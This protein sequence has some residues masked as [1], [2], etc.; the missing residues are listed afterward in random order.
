MKSRPQP[1]HVSGQAGAKRQNALLYTFLACSGISGQVRDRWFH[2]IVREARAGEGVSPNNSRL[3]LRLFAAA[4]RKVRFHHR[5]ARVD[6]LV[7][8]NKTEQGKAAVPPLSLPDNTLPETVDQVITHAIAAL[9]IK[10]REVLLLLDVLGLTDA[11]AGALLDLDLQTLNSRRASARLS[12]AKK[13]AAHSA[14][15]E[16]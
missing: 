10:N 15:D 9:P 13:L 14:L 1:K 2:E 16:V 3:E 11:D 8:A 6:R 5:Q 7:F 4:I 12:L